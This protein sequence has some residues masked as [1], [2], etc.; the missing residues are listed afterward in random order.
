MTERESKHIIH[1]CAPVEIVPLDI[2]DRVRPLFVSHGN[3][4]AELSLHELIKKNMQV[5]TNLLSTGVFWPSH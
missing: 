2:V 4:T 5:S 1:K 3:K